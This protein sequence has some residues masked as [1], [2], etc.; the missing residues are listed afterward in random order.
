MWSYIKKAIN[1]N[2]LNK[3]LDK[4]IIDKTNSTY[5]TEN[6]PFVSF[7]RILQGEKQYKSN[8]NMKEPIIAEY[9]E[10]STEAKL[11]KI[12]KGQYSYY[13]GVYTAGKTGRIVVRFTTE[14]PSYG[15]EG[16]YYIYKNKPPWTDI[17]EYDATVFG[18]EILRGSIALQTHT[19]D[20]FIYVE[21]DDK[22]YFQYSCATSYHKALYNITILGQEE[23]IP[24]ITIVDKNQ[25]KEGNN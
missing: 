3:S 25:E 16:S 12:N 2:F 17:N 4:I 24:Y 9:T 15:S 23:E 14:T 11:H 13:R 6:K 19:T 20:N 5:N 10:A 8:I 1:N 22:I 7:G 21:K 18:N